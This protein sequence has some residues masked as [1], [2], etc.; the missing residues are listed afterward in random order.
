M[1]FPALGLF[2]PSNLVLRALNAFTFFSLFPPYFFTLT[3]DLLS[4]LSFFSLLCLM[5]SLK[6]IDF[7][8]GVDGGSLAN[9]LFRMLLKGESCF[10]VSSRNECCYDGF[11][12]SV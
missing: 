10:L 6:L 5:T 11:W 8:L 3:L 1:T 4:S 2:S 12:S 9:N 7:S